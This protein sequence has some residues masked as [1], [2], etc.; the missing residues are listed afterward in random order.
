M[1]MVRFAHE[2]SL[3]DTFTSKTIFALAIFAAMPPLFVPQALVLCAEH[4]DTYA[5]VIENYYSEETCYE[6]SYDSTNAFNAFHPYEVVEAHG[7]ES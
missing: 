1:K 3:F 4:A 5:E 2:I 6:G 7:V